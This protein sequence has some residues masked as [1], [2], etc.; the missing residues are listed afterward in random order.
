MLWEESQPTLHFLSLF[1]ALTAFKT[2]A[3][4]SLVISPYQEI[5]MKLHSYRRLLEVYRSPVCLYKR[6]IF[7][8]SFLFFPAKQ[9]SSPHFQCPQPLLILTAEVALKMSILSCSPVTQPFLSGEQRQGREKSRVSLLST[10]F[11]KYLMSFP[12]SGRGSTWDQIFAKL[13]SKNCT[14][15]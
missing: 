14:C 5:Q 10:K 8:A 4:S 13:G 9:W 7:L 3:A 6:C 2:W 1:W 15:H 11:I 12:L